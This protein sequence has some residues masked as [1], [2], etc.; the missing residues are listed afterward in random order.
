MV[1]F[2]I[3]TVPEQTGIFSSFNSIS[4]QLESC[5]ETMMI[6]GWFRTLLTPFGVFVN[7]SEVFSFGMYDC[8]YDLF[9]HQTRGSV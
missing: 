9:V 5:I 2:S 1:I 6:A 4:V 3:F 8:Q 7:E